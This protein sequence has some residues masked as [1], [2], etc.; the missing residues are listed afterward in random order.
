MPFSWAYLHS[1]VD[2]ERTLEILADILVEETETS[3]PA[4]LLDMNIILIRAQESSDP[5]VQASLSI[6]LKALPRLSATK[7]EAMKAQLFASKFVR[8]TCLSSDS[9]SDG[10]F[11]PSL[12]SED[13]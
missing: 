5:L 8:E 1:N 10:E 13:R 12:F 9:D 3:L 2:D 7:S 6:L 11:L 4:G